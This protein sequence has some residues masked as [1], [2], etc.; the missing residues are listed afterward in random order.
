MAL[1]MQEITPLG[2][3]ISTQDLI[4]GRRFQQ[5]FCDNLLLRDR[6]RELHAKLMPIK[7]DLNSKVQNRYLDGHKIAIVSNIDKIIAVV[8]SRYAEIDLNLVDSIVFNGKLLIHKVLNSES[9]DK[10]AELEPVFKSKITLPVYDLFVRNSEK[11]NL[12]KK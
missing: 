4:D 1:A 3:C 9:F 8:S 10:I 7:R 2:L 5:N 6:D 11:R 12:F